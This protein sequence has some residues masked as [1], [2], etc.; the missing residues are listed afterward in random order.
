[1]L[2]ALRGMVHLDPPF[3]APALRTFV[4][5]VPT[6]LEDRIAMQLCETLRVRDGKGH[7][8]AQ[9]LVMTE[10]VDASQ[11]DG[12]SET[13]PVPVRWKI[14]MESMRAFVDEARYDNV[15]TFPRIPLPEV[16]RDADWPEFLGVWGHTAAA[17]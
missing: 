12:S 2:Q 11:G 9:L 17:Y 5:M 3:P 6:P 15:D 1:M 7:R 4:C 8:L 16:C 13:L 14:Q 10:R